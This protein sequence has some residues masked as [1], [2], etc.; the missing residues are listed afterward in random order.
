VAIAPPARPERE[1]SMRAG[2][3]K[4]GSKGAHQKGLDLVC[5]LCPLL[6][7]LCLIV[8]VFHELLQVHTS[9][10]P[11]LCPGMGTKGFSGL[12]P[13]S[14]PALPPSPEALILD[15]GWYEEK[16]A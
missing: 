7:L 1:S 6:Y 8:E 13:L 15:S 12:W 10:G 9:L 3:V 14:L 16:R 5:R 4:E 11:R 2:V